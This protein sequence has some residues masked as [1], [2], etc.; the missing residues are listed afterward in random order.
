MSRDCICRETIVIGVCGSIAASPEGR[1]A[2]LG[3]GRGGGGQ[4][5]GGGGESGAGA[6]RTTR[7]VVVPVKVPAMNSVVSRGSGSLVGW[8]WC[9]WGG[10]GRG[11]SV[12]RNHEWGVATARKKV[13]GIYEWYM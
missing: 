13:K 12:I 2:G 3:P 10:G 1:A 9:G 5:G 6:Y 4:P 8:L 7:E 11:G